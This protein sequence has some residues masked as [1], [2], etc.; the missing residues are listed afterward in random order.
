[1]TS[2]FR[3]GLRA[4]LPLAVPTGLLG[5]TFGA[6]AVASGWPPAAPIVASVVIFSGTAQFA[7]LTVLASGGG[8]AM[9]VGSAALFNARFVPMGVALGPSLRGGRMRRAVEG[10]TNV[11]GSWVIAHE[12]DGRFDRH[13][14]FGATTGQL[15]AWI[16]GTVVGVVA[17][18]PQNMFHDF[19]LDVIYPAFFLVL[20]LEEL[21]EGGGSWRVAV[22]SAALAAALLWIV[23]PGVTLLLCAAVALTGL[24]GR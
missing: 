15:V 20:L 12:G 10:M 3:D 5:V 1:M 22:A 19:G 23:S 6:T 7:L 18:P 13:K 16:S 14:L 11:D 9:A 2:G 24:R 17:A 8:V 21:R 4:S